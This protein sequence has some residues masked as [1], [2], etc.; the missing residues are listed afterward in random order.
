MPENII[1][2][3]GGARSGKSS[4]AEKY[5]AKC[6]KKIAYIATAQVRDREMEARIEL[7]KRRRPAEWT[8]Y[9]APY[10]AHI[11]IDLASKEHD[12][13]LFDCLTLY[14][15][16]MLCEENALES[17]KAR[18]DKVKEQVKKL[19]AGARRSGRQTIFVTNEVGMGI[20]PENALAREYRDL[21]GTV[22]QMMAKA[23]AET[24]LVVA[25]I[26]VDVKKLSAQWEE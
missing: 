23:A 22:N 16:N 6:G 10:D 24:Y 12:A 15:S 8:T 18:A 14:V 1:L 20:V 2:V 3:T 21:A 25:G 9:E 7:H 19:I 11:S 13:I 26:A 17:A 4:F 5:A